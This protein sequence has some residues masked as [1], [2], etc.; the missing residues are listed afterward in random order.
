M[1]SW[2]T[3]SSGKCDNCVYTLLST[4]IWSPFANGTS[5]ERQIQNSLAIGSPTLEMWVDSW[6]QKSKDTKLTLTH[7]AQ[8]LLELSISSNI[9]TSTTYKENANVNAYFPIKIAQID[10]SRSYLLATPKNH[11]QSIYAISYGGNISSELI[12]VYAGQQPYGALRPVICI[13][14]NYK[15]QYNAESAEYHI[16]E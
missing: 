1:V 15:L 4:D 6:N 14:S 13:P 11:T 2:D 16:V 10:K 12:H 8:D 5:K 7:N 9:K 3:T